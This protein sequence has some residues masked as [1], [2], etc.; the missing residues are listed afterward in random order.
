[1]PRARV[2]TL[3]STRRVGCPAPAPAAIATSPTPTGPPDILASGT[4]RAE[5]DVAPHPADPGN[6]LRYQ[7]HNG[8]RRIQDPAR[9][10]DGNAQWTRFPV[11]ACAAARRC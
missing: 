5:F 8:L 2:Q 3:L 4:A 7:G 11:R 1:M 9:S 6:A 10:P